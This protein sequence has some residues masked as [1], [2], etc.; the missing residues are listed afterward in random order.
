MQLRRLGMAALL[1]GCLAVPAAATPVDLELIMAF[2]TSG[3]VDGVDFS[4]RRAATA[5]AFRDAGVI[6]KIVN[7]AI[8]SIAVT[9]WDF[10][11]TVGVAVDWMLVHDAASANALADAIEAAGRLDGGDDGQA[12]MLRKAAIAINA[13]DYEGTRRVV[14]I[15]SEG[16]QTAGCDYTS[17][18]CQATRDAR[19]VFLAAGG[20]AVN[21]LWMRD[22]DYFGIHAGVITN[23]LE[24]GAMSVIG[25]TN[26]FQM[27]A[28]T[29]QDFV[30]GI[31]AKLVREI[32]DPGPDVP[33]PATMTLLGVSLLGLAARRRRH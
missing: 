18:D 32:T 31:N 24:Y 27:F 1:S 29:N 3:S 23:A 15:V 22:R 9:L 33:E 13:N 5:A 7:G 6:D 8:G 16:V 25:G 19:D 26:S 14:D 21:A 11:T 4:S 10:G 2:D 28:E 17:P 12:Y 20:S 30:A